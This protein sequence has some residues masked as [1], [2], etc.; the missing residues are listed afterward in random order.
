LSYMAVFGETTIFSV[1]VNSFHALGSSTGLR[2]AA[3]IVK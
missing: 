2:S 3:A 1:N